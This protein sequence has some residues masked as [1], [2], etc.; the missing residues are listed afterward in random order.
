VLGEVENRWGQR[1]G[2]L[3][4]GHAGEA[5]PL[6]LEPAVEVFLGAFFEVRF[7]VEKIEL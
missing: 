5:L 1:E 4:G 3:T 2:G 7:V 6:L